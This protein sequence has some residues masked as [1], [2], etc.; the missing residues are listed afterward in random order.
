MDVAQR[1][2][3]GWG[4]L[5]AAAA[6][7]FAVWF[8]FFPQFIPQY[9]AWDIQ[10]RFAQ[11]FIGAGYVFRTFFFLNA[12]FER[13]WLRLR[14]I[15]WGNLVFT[16]ILLLATYWHAEEFHWNPFETPLAHIWI[17]LYIFEPVVMIYL[18]PRGTFSAP[19][20]T[21]GGPI[22]LWFKRFL[23]LVTGLLLMN[24]LLLVINPEFA[25][26]RWAWELNPLDARMVS[27][28][29]LGWSVWCGTMAFAQDWDEIRTAARL[30]ILNGV[31]LF[32]VT[33]LF[34]DE[35]LP[36]RGTA[37]GFAVAVAVDDRRHGRVPRAPGP[38]PADRS[39][40]ARRAQRRGG[41]T[42]GLPRASLLENARFTLTYALPSLLRGALIPQPF[43]TELA[44]RLNTGQWAVATVERLSG[45]H[46]GRSLLLRGVLGETLLILTTEDVRRVLDSPVERVRA[47]RPREAARARTVRARRAQR[48][49]ARPSAPSAARSTRRCSTTATSRIGSPSG[50]SRSSARRSRRCSGR[51]ASWTTSDRSQASVGSAAAACSATRRPMTSS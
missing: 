31:A 10:P 49:T 23:V 6:A 45:R 41:M 28:W 9:F 5:G 7:W 50:S 16:G 35:F 13:S 18:I 48:V 11:V 27:A 12:A 33:V 46:G 40:G 42:T 17:V 26:T 19:P 51:P 22:N 8:L 2:R 36:G 4:L 25:A 37:T 30:F 38:A 21:S 3:L 43:W 24:G 39:T 44:T 32:V 29:F 1:S 14:W 15:V 47:R 20:P 34:R